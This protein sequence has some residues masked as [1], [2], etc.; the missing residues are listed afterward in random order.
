MQRNVEYSTVQVGRRHLV[1]VQYVADGLIT[2]INKRMAVRLHRAGT[3][4]IIGASG[5][6][7][8]KARQ[9]AGLNIDPAY[10]QGS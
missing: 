10:A 6:K 1:P 9:D 5:W 7:S 2:L 3:V 8:I 4:D